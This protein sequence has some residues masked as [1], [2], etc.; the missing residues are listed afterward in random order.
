MSTIN[1]FPNRH[2]RRKR[3]ASAFQMLDTSRHAEADS[4]PQVIEPSFTAPGE[5]AVRDGLVSA[6]IN[7]GESWFSCSGRRGGSGGVSFGWILFSPYQSFVEYTG[8][9]FEDLIP[10][11]SKRACPCLWQ[12]GVVPKSRIMVAAGSVA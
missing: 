9:C 1:D 3:T 5:S 4:A 7:N 6:G 12:A 2:G 8:V 10:R 11:D